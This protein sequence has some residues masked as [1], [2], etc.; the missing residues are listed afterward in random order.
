MT[1]SKA[2]FCC[3]QVKP[4]S[5][6]G[7]S[8]RSECLDGRSNY[9]K[10]CLRDNRPKV[11]QDKRFRRRFGI[12]LADRDRLA[13]SQN[14]ECALCYSEEPLHLDH[15]SKHPQRVIR[16]LLCF[17]CNTGIGKLQHDPEILARAIKYLEVD[18][19][20]GVDYD[21]SDDDEDDD[22]ED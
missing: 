5:Y 1:T 11:E 2:C 3:E 21:G 18:R 20:Y 4:L 13:K 12:S 10:A 15:D 7:W 22:D 8:T 9:C 14:Y 6:F 17:D 16:G 19:E